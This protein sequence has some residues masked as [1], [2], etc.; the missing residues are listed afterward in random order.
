E[1]VRQR[2]RTILPP[3][4]PQKEALAELVVRVEDELVAAGE[5]R[6][7]LDLRD[8]ARRR[9]LDD[10]AGELAAHDAEVAERGSGGE[11]PLVVEQH[12]PR[13]RPAAAG[14]AV[15]LPVGEDGDV[16]LRERRSALLL[17]EDHPVDVP[18]LG[19]VRVDDVVRRLEVGLDRPAE[20]DQP[21]QLARLDRLLERRVE[22][23]AERDVDLAARRPQAPPVDERRNVAEAHRPD[24]AAVQAR[25]RRQP[26]G[27]DVDHNL[28]ALHQPA[29]DRPGDERDRPVAAGGRVA[30]VV[31]EDGAEI[32][33][34]VLGLGDEAAVHVGMPAGLVDQQAADVVEPLQ[35]EPP[36]LEDRAAL[37]PLDAARDDPERLVVGLVVDRRDGGQLPVKDAGRFSRKAFTPSAKS[38]VFVAAVCSSA[39]RASCSSSVASW[40]WSKSRFVI[41]MPRVGRAA[42]SAASSA[43]RSASRPASTTSSTSPHACASAA[44]SFRFELIHM[45]AREGPSRRAMKYEPPESGTRPMPMN[46]GT[47][48]AESAAMR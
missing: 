23:A 48:E 47:N 40:A 12:E 20:L 35:R 24:A 27:R 26:A 39:S 16:A 41:P 22:R 7:A 46:P 14:R 1:L 17:P 25:D 33:A 30:G 15:D 38:A 29:L 43:A 11:P 37:E 45:N 9:L 42:K 28:R 4:L 18:Q 36:L 10:A 21:R 34:V 3:R 2:H 13:R 32:G 6:A 8:H 31:E 5:V 19:L 44:P